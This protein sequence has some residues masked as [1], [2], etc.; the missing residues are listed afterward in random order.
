[1]APERRAIMLIVVLAIAGQVVRGLLGAPESAP[2]DLV[3]LPDPGG[4]TGAMA[5]HRARALALA[6]PLGASERIDLDRATAEEIARLPQVGMALARRIVASRD[7][8]GPFGSMEGLDRVP[9]VGPGLMGRIAP[10]ATF[11][12][13]PTT[14]FHGL[15]PAVQPG[16]ASLDLNTADSAA[17]ERLPGVG[18]Y[19][20]GRIVAYRNR[21]GRFLSVEELV[22]VGGVGEKTLARIRGRVMV[23]R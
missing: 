22:K 8:Q 20:A 13:R 23:G 17:L 19:L 2:G 21:H 1:M 9:G 7:S 10:H 5:A 16:G 12:A 18:P 11:S 6:R 15:A 3:L 4:G 14:A